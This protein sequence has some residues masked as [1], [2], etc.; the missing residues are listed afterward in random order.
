VGVDGESQEF[1]IEF[2][3]ANAQVGGGLYNHGLF[4]FHRNHE[5]NS[6]DVSHSK[7]SDLKLN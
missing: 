3:T 1:I 6:S 5:K 4:F 7:S 2:L